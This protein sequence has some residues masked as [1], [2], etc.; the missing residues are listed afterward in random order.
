MTERKTTGLLSIFRRLD[1]GNVPA[2]WMPP[3]LPASTAAPASAK[4]D[5]TKSP[6]APW[7]PPELPASN[8]TPAPAKRDRTIAKL[9]PWVPPREAPRNLPAAPE[10]ERGGPAAGDGDSS[11]TADLQRDERRPADPPAQNTGPA[12]QTTIIVQQVAAPAP[13][14]VPYGWGCPRLY[15]PRHA[16]RP[17]FR[18]FCWWW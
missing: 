10:R 4:R 6:P 2:P 12:G 14:Y 1:A 17:C 8:A 7:V 9:K 11:K 15:C 3:E 16:G 13:V 5:R 18:L